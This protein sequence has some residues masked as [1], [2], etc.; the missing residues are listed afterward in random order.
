MLVHGDLVTKN[1]RVQHGLGGTNSASPALLVFDW[2]NAGWGIAATDLAE[3]EGRALAPD[4]NSYLENLDGNSRFSRATLR[5][6]VECGRVF[7]LLDSIHWAALMLNCDSYDSLIVPISRLEV[8]L[9]RMT[10]ALRPFGRTRFPAHK[11][12]Y[13]DNQ[14]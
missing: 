8:Y 10:K 5:R 4:P 6:V 12:K 3:T 13:A 1:V 7:R 11:I 9:L 14:Y 2:E